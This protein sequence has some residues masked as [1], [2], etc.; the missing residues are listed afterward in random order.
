VN[1]E[2]EIM[3]K[4]GPQNVE[5]AVFLIP[6][7]CPECGSANWVITKTVGYECDFDLAWQSDSAVEFDVWRVVNVTSKSCAACNF[8]PHPPVVEQMVDEMVSPEIV[9]SIGNKEGTAWKKVAEKYGPHP[10]GVWIDTRQSETSIEQ[11]HSPYL[12]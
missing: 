1:R 5:E 7:A 8:I 3:A 9:T 4:G 11:V 2:R 10:R 12:S 6:A